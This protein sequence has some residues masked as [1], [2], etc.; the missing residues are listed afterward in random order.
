MVQREEKLKI[1]H[2]EE[3]VAFLE[4]VLNQVKIIVSVF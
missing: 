4:D 2:R 1:H 3:T